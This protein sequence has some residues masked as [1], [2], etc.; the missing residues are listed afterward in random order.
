MRTRVLNGVGAK[1]W[2][3]IR[4]RGLDGCGSGLMNANVKQNPAR[5]YGGGRSL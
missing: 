2:S 4:E 1:F 3:G 5:R